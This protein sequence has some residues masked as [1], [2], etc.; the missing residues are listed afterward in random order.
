MYRLQ[1]VDDTRAKQLDAW[2]D[3]VVAWAKAN[4]ANKLT[5]SDFPY[6]HNKKLK[7]MWLLLLPSTGAVCGWVPASLSLTMQLIPFP[8]RQADSR[9]HQCSCRTCYPKRYYCKQSSICGSL[10]VTKDKNLTAYFVVNRVWR[11]GRQRQEAPCRVLDFTS[12][13]GS[14]DL[15]L[16]TQQQSTLPP[17]SNKCNGN[18]TDLYGVL[19]A[20]GVGT[21]HGG[22]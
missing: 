2:R 22:L 16:C 3:L 5:L 13:V 7:R 4:R 9:R 10:L 18:A 8:P 12:R 1:V 6:W 21:W 19:C 15:R 11:V 17:S 14:Q 20:S